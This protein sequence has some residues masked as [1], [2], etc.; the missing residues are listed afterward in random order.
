MVI[1]HSWHTE[2][3]FQ[4]THIQENSKVNLPQKP[5][6]AHEG[7]CDSPVVTEVNLLIF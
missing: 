7:P 3:T 6:Q 1:L 2:C 5:K 4:M